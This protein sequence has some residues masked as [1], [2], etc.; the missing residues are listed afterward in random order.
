MA[1]IDDE[2]REPGESGQAALNAGR[3][4]YWFA[5]LIAAVIVVFVVA[6]VFISWAQGAPIVRIMALIA[7]LAVWLIGC[8]CRAVLP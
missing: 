4:L 1:W 2:W 6:D 5:T 7:A 8:I 3:T